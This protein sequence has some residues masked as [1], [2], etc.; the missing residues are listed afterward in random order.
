MRKFDQWEMVFDMLTIFGSGT[1]YHNKILLWLDALTDVFLASDS[2]KQ[3]KFGVLLFY[4][5]IY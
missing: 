2:K 1:L 3:M 5:L 4:V